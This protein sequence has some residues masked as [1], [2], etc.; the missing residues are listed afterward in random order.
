MRRGILLAAFIL[1]ALVGC[2]EDSS[3][4]RPAPAPGEPIDVARNG[5]ETEDKDIQDRI[6]VT[7]EKV[8]RTEEYVRSL[9]ETRDYQLQRL[10]AM[11]AKKAKT[12]KEAAVLGRRLSDLERLWGLDKACGG[13]RRDPLT[14]VSHKQFEC[15]ERP[16]AFDAL[17]RKPTS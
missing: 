15:L 16:K 12:E 5:A 11:E 10:A 14:Q 13:A 9:E 17:A 7:R 2:R 1:P 4:E 3:S 6:K 8:G